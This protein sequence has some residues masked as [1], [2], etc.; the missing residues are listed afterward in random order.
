VCRA[1]AQWHAERRWRNDD[2]D[3]GYDDWADITVWDPRG[4]DVAAGGYPTIRASIY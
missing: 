1:V 3:L 2:G 4:E